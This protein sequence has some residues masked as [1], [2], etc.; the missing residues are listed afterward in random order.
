MADV[1]ESI[2]SHR[3]YRPALGVRKALEEIS[4]KKNIYYD[5]EVVD[6]CVRLFNK[7]NF[8]FE[9]D[10]PEEN[11]YGYYRTPAYLMPN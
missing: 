10:L 4:N 8:T 9:S 2:S 5:S 1:V 3:P 7:K 6:A 11:E